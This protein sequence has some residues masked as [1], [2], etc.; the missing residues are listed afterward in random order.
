MKYKRYF[1]NKNR[2]HFI[3]YLLACWANYTKHEHAYYQCSDIFNLAGRKVLLI[4]YLL[5]FVIRLRIELS[6]GLFQQ[7]VEKVSL[8]LCWFLYCFGWYILV[9]GFL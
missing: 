9:Y 3:L 7:L 1:I 6:I 5:I 8:G 2:I 4:G